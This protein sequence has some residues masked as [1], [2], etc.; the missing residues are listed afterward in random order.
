M[1]HDSRA[2]SRRPRIEGPQVTGRW[3]QL[4]GVHRPG[5]RRPCLRVGTDRQAVRPPT[6]DRRR[7]DRERRDV[8]SCRVG[9]S[10]GVDAGVR[11]SRGW[12]SEGSRLDPDPGRSLRRVST[13]TRSAHMGED[14]RANL[15]R[16]PF[17]TRRGRRAEARHVRH[18]DPRRR[19]HADLAAR[20]TSGDLARDQEFARPVIHGLGAPSAP[21]TAACSSWRCPA[22]RGH[23]AD[24]CPVPP[25]SRQAAGLISARPRTA[26]RGGRVAVGGAP[27]AQNRG[28]SGER[29]LHPLQCGQR[30][31]V[32]LARSQRTRHL[33]I[34]LH[35]QQDR[36][37]L[38]RADPEHG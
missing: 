34:V 33:R 24:R 25:R 2:G 23:R 16:L 35:K 22:R 10:P 8:R 32:T 1:P 26:G 36:A 38:S 30:S 3:S 29:H 21:M 18:G 11:T 5:F 4:G 9:F 12:G 37:V 20:R 28:E 17:A 6:S 19:Y 27:W 13:P 14:R 15:G 7:P 31:E